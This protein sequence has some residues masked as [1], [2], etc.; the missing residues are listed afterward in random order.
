M[1]ALL[2]LSDFLQQDVYRR[3][4]VL[5]PNEPAE[6]APGTETEW[7]QPWT[8]STPRDPNVETMRPAERTTQD[9]GP[10]SVAVQIGRAVARRGS[11]DGF[12]TPG[13]FL[14]R[15]VENPP[16][17]SLDNGT[18]PAL[19]T[20]ATFYA[21]D[22]EDD[23]ADRK[24]KEQQNKQGEDDEQQQQQQQQQQQGRRRRRRRRRRMEAK[25]VR[26]VPPAA[27][28]SEQVEGCVRP[29]RRRGID[30][31]SE[32][33]PSQPTA[34][35]SIKKSKTAAKPA[36]APAGLAKT[37]PKRKRAIVER[38]GMVRSD[39]PSLSFAQP[40][41]GCSKLAWW[42]KLEEDVQK[43]RLK[44]RQKE[45]KERQKVLKE[46]LVQKVDCHSSSCCPSVPAP[47]SATAPLPL[48]LLSCSL[49]SSVP[50]GRRHRR[51]SWSG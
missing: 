25:T 26:S 46:R 20:D 21:F 37:R 8:G 16:P 14:L 19:V 23:S 22:F 36:P 5:V 27:A 9:E 4:G 42:P 43:E 12:S 17:T 10:P 44:E 51:R 29:R 24:Q 3:E 45:L 15:P 18:K 32:M 33:H 35:L 47:P 28:A 31:P 39:D 50:L 49:T 38:P 30:R 1:G 41:G 2:D 11:D 13:T 7:F 6:N 34:S 40:K 48:L